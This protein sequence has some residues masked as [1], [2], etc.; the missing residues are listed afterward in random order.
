MD[1][2]VWSRG[3]QAP[4]PPRLTERDRLRQATALMLSTD[5]AAEWVDT[6]AELTS[7]PRMIEQYTAEA[8]ARTQDWVREAPPL[9]VELADEQIEEGDLQQKIQDLINGGVWIVWVVRREGPRRVEVHALNQPVRRIP[10]ERD[11]TAPGILSLPVPARAFFE[12]EAALEQL[13][14]RLELATSTPLP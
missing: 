6:A 3:E 13:R 7:G 12:H 5:P 11:L 1:V 14:L 9:V 8:G 10:I 4:E 2:V